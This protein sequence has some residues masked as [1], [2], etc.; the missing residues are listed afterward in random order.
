MRPDPGLADLFGI[1]YVSPRAEHLLQF[2]KYDT[3]SVP[4]TGIVDLSLQ[5]HG[6][7]DNYS[8]NGAV[9]LA[10]LWDCISTPSSTPA[11]VENAYGDGLAAAYTFDLA[12]SI[13]LTRQGNPAWKDS[14]GDGLG[15][16]RPGDLFFRQNGDKWLAPERTRVPQADEQQRFLANLMLGMMDSPLPRM[17]YLPDGKKSL[18]VNTGD[19]EDLCRVRNLTTLSTMQP[20][21]AGHSPAI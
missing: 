5:Y 18:M 4:G 17:W 3:S 9:A 15:G 13:V 19:A 6:Q 8:L 12:K 20:V 11:V 1:T 7:A 14:E 10:N 16:Y 21:M 2:L